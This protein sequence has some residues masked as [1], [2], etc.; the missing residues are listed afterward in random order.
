MVLDQC[1]VCSL[2]ELGE[3]EC[4]AEAP[5][6]ED[7]LFDCEKGASSEWSVAKAAWCCEHHSKACNRAETE[8]RFFQKKVAES[9]MTVETH[10]SMAAVVIAGFASIGVSIA[11][12]LRATRQSSRN[13]VHSGLLSE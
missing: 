10:S 13:P 5:T 7:R 8:T 4:G 2:C 11:L 1:S 9:G 3:S 6:N 12:I